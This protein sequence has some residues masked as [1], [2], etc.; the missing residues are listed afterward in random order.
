MIKLRFTALQKIYIKI[1]KITQ[2]KLTN[3]S[4]KPK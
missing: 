1:E 2:I 4:Q 3:R